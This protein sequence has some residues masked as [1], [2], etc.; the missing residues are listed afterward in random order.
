MTFSYSFIK[1]P[2]FRNLSSF[3]FILFCVLSFVCVLSFSQSQKPEILLIP[4]LFLSVPLFFVYPQISLFMLFASFFSGSY[5]YVEKYFFIS[6]SHVFFI[7]SMLGF[8]SKYFFK[9][10]RPDISLSRPLLTFLLLFFI[11]AVLSF[12]LN[13]G[14]HTFSAL[15]SLSYLFNFALLIIAFVLFSSGAL[16]QYK[17]SIIVFIL[18]LSFL[19][20]PVVFYQ[21][22]ALGK[23]YFASYRD[24]TGTFGSHHS[25]LANMMTF[26]LGFS[27]FKLLDKPKF[28]HFLFFTFLTICSLCAIIYSGSR[29]NIIGI[30]GAILVLALLRLRLK[31]IYFI[32]FGSFI[33]ALFLLLKLTPIPHLI[34]ST[35]HSKETGFLDISSLWRIFIWKYFWNHYWHSGIFCKLFGVGMANSMTISLPEFF[36]NSKLVGGAHNNFLHV[37]IETGFV[38]FLFFM[39]FYVTVLI[40]LYRQSSYDRLALAYF[41]IT[42]SLLLSGITQET[43]WFQPVFGCL[44]LYHTC[45]LALILDNKKPG[46]FVVS[47]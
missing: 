22:I 34:A 37:L 2:S 20:I 1:R 46:E 27:L 18:L 39:A 32:Y 21:V 36:G 16:K 31:A 15:F 45:L 12:L 14:N 6:W 44:W 40:K 4:L 13:I 23:N 29:S 10:T 28:K 8:L 42:L 5:I 19:E 43:F 7:L 17:N 25:M 33:F 41:F 24:I 9:K 11:V 35:I 3:S 38:G 26:P 30:T 47:T